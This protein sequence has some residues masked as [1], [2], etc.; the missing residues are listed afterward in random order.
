MGV[1]EYYLFEISLTQ[2]HLMPY[3]RFSIVELMRVYLIYRI[4]YAML[5]SSMQHLLFM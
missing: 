2:F 3:M 5:N 1:I 4:I